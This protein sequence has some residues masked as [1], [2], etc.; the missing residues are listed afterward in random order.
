MLAYFAA[1][2]LQTLTGSGS[3]GQVLGVQNTAGINQATAFVAAATIATFYT[4]VAGQISAISAARGIAPDTIVMAP[5][6]YAWLLAQ[7]D[8]QGRPLVTPAPEQGPM[9]TMGVTGEAPTYGTSAGK[10]L[11][12]DI[13][14]DANVPL[15]VGSGPEDLVWVYRRSDILLYEQN[16]GTP[17]ELRFE[18]TL[19]SQLTVTLVLYGYLAFTAGRYPTAVGQIGGNSAAGFGLISPSF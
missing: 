17:R 15:S 18:Q 6:R 1:L 3:S 11:G 9:N 10:F 12:L 16:G 7:V 2:D 4:K 13:V 8:S 19:A 5:R 14:V